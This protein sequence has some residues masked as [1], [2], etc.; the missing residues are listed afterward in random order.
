MKKIT[1]SLNENELEMIIGIMVESISNNN[2]MDYIKELGFSDSDIEELM[3]RE[4]DR[5][6]SVDYSSHDIK[7][8]NNEL[9]KKLIEKFLF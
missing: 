5:V 4:E 6:S 9:M 8:M 2:A 3:S 7:E 1:L